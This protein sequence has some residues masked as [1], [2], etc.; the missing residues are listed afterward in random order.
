M[1]ASLLISNLVAYTLPR[2]SGFSRGC[3]LPPADH[4]Q[5]GRR[6]R[7]LDKRAPTEKGQKTWKSH[8]YQSLRWHQLQL[9][10]V[11]EVADHMRGS[12]PHN[13]SWSIKA[14]KQQACLVAISVRIPLAKVQLL[15]DELLVS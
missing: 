14:L 6:L 10:M 7:D 2:I 8:F 11:M 9:I 12:E 13:M 3:T 4:F 15:A 5:P 1:T